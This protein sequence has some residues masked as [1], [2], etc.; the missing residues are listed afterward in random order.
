MQPAYYSAL[1]KRGIFLCSPDSVD[2]AR[3]REWLPAPELG[4]A[5]WIGKDGK[6]RYDTGINNCNSQTE[7]AWAA[8]VFEQLGEYE[9]G[10][11]AAD[12]DLRLNAPSPSVQ[13]EANLARGRCFAKLG[14]AAEAEEAF[15]KAIVVSVD[16]I[17]PFWEMLAR[18]DLIVHVLDAAGRREEQMPL[19]GKCI[20]GL[21]LPPIEY[22]SVL[23]AD[24]DP[25]AAVALFRAQEG[26]EG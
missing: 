25:E 16:A 24:L 8:E 5:G 3:F 7:G 2:T 19:L 26:Q 4:S 13:L 12:T 6:E 17:W 21:V 15:G 10:I 11:V 14:R 20:A 18:R 9:N 1:M 22:A 23:G